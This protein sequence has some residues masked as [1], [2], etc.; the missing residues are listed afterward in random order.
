MSKPIARVVFAVLISLALIAATSTS[1]R[2]WLGRIMPKV[3]ANT[4]QVHIVNGLQTNFNHYR[5]SV[6]E[7]QS[8]Q[9]QIDTQSADQPGKGHGCHSDS[10]INPDD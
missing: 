10:Q 5:S 8:I 9:T 1:A 3:G 4:A 6:Y 7:L 2:G